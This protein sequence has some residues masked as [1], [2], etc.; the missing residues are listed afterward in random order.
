MGTYV[1]SQG[2]WNL[3]LEQNGPNIQP[4]DDCAAVTTSLPITLTATDTTP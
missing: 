4:E 1:G 2:Q 3:L